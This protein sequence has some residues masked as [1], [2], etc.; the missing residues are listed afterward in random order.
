MTIMETY[1]LLQKEAALWNWIHPIKSRRLSRMAAEDAKRSGYK[2]QFAE[3]ETIK[4]LRQ[5]KVP[6]EFAGS[7]PFGKDVLLDFIDR[8]N[9][10]IHRVR[11]PIP[12]EGLKELF[13]E[14]KI[15]PDELEGALSK[16]A[17]MTFSK[18][19]L[20][21]APVLGGAGLLYLGWR[22]LK[23]RHQNSTSTL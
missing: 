3:P 10:V 9:G 12:K 21:M 1:L 19:L 22:A 14:Y 15:K 6:L 23:N 17:P 8:R 13:K 2:V 4:S 7:R 16:A 11:H 5:A 18:G 20:H